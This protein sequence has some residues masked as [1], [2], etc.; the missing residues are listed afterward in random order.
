MTQVSANLPLPAA[1]LYQ[2]RQDPVA[3]LNSIDKLLENFGAEAVG[4]ASAQEFL[5]QFAEGLKD[6]VLDSN[7]PD[8]IKQMALAKIDQHVSD[9]GVAPS[10][11]ISSAIDNSE[12]SQEIKTAVEEALTGLFPSQ[13]D[14]GAMTEGAMEAVREAIN[15][16]GAAFVA[17]LSPSDMEAI[18][19][20]INEG[21]AASGAEPSSSA[22]QAANE[23]FNEGGAASDAEAE[24]E[25][26]ALNEGGSA[27]GETTAA[28]EANAD[29]ASLLAD[30]AEGEEKK[31]TKGGG[32]GHFLEALAKAM[33][34]V[35]GNMLRQAKAHSD[36]MVAQSGDA[37]DPQ[38][39]TLAQ[40][41]YTAKMQMFNIYSSQVATSLKTIGEAMAGI[42][43]KQ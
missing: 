7:L 11:D 14:A 31:K 42:A 1:L 2:V 43:R 41:Q 36:T 13:D 16:G 32:G 34:Q 4:Q 38:A 25:S 3:F 33:G 30:T 37:G 10:E 26:E 17:E 29:M 20:A 35:Q 8:S 18:S 21:G 15:E 6:M 28:D 12:L 22:A 40:A 23:A 5:G 19:E 39:F 24:A 27:A 9:M